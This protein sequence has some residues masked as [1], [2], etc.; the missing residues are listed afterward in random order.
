MSPLILRQVLD[1]ERFN[2]F[3]LFVDALQILERNIIRLTDI[4]T[5]HAK[6][7][8]F[9]IGFEHLYGKRNVT[10][11]M[12]F[13]LHLAECI[14]MYG[15]ISCFWA[16]NF[17][18]YNMFVKMVRTNHKKGFEKTFMVQMLRIIHAEDYAG[19]FEKYI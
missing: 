13:H 17:E 7:R 3:M 10:S 19:L 15:P 6:L 11:N 1:T 5:C 14:R 12:H 9:C 8:E 18:R 4:D 2:N 16:F